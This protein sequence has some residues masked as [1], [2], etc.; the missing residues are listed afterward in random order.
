VSHL[1]EADYNSNSL[2]TPITHQSALGTD[3]KECE[4]NIPIA[5]VKVSKCK[6]TSKCEIPTINVCKDNISGTSIC[7]RQDVN[8]NKSEKCLPEANVSKCKENISFLSLNVCGL[9]SKLKM[10]DFE[11]YIAAVDVIALGESNICA[12]DN[13]N[14]KGFKIIETLCNRKGIGRISLLVRN[15]LVPHVSIINKSK[16]VVI[17]FKL[18]SLFDNIIFGAMYIPPQNSPHSNICMFDSIE[19]DVIELR[20]EFDCKLCIFGDTNART[21]EMDDYVLIENYKVNEANLEYEDIVNDYSLTELDLQRLNI[22]LQRKSNDKKT[23]KYGKRLIDLCK[24]LNLL[25]LNG[26]A[27]IDKGVGQ[28]TCKNASLVDYFICSPELFPLV[29]QFEVDTFDPTLS[30][31]HNPLILSLQSSLP[32]KCTL[33]GPYESEERWSKSNPKPR[34]NKDKETSFIQCINIQNIQKL[35]N[36][37]EDTSKASE[38][39]INNVVGGIENTLKTSA[40]ECGMIKKRN[41]HSK[42]PKKSVSKPWFNAD[43]QE[44]RKAFMKAKKAC[45]LINSPENIAN[46]KFCSSQYKKAT[47]QAYKEY[48]EALTL[49]L[50]SL[51]SSKPKEYWDILNDGR[52]GNKNEVYPPAEELFEHFRDMNESPNLEQVPHLEAEPL[53]P[54]SSD[55]KPPSNEPLNRPITSEEITKAVNKLKNNKSCGLDGIINEYLKTTAP[56][57]TPLFVKLFNRVLDTGIIPKSWALGKIIPIFKNKGDP[58]NPNSYRGITI[59]SC[60]GKLFTAI[61]NTRIEEYLNE[62]NLLG[63]EQ[64]GFRK[65]H[66]T[67]DHIFLLNSLID[68]YLQKRKRLY[69]AF[70]DYEKAF[71]KIDRTLLWTKLIDNGINGKVLSV[72]TNLYK[73][74]KSCIEKEGRTS[75]FFCC[76]VGVRQGENLSP[77]LF[78]LYL[79]DLTI[80]LSPALKGLQVTNDLL[81]RLGQTKDLDNLIKLFVL[82]YADDTT[83]LAD[84]PEALQ[85]GL[86][87]MS[88]YCTKWKIKINVEKT[89]IVVFSRGKIRKK[90]VFSYNDT[91]IEIVDDFVYLGTLINY[92]GKSNKTKKRTCDQASKAMFSIIGKAR[93]LNLPVEIQMHLF[94]SVVLPI[95]LYG[96]EVWGSQ[97]VRDI[98]RVH[99]KFCKMVLGLSQYTSSAMVYGETGRVPLIITIKTRIVAF[100]HKLLTTLSPK[101]SCSMY[102]LLFQVVN[103]GLGE[104]KWINFVQNILDECGLSYI[105]LNQATTT[106]DIN[107][108]WLKAKIKMSLTDQF[109]QQWHDMIN[110]NDNCETYRNFKSNITME[111]YLLCL[112]FKARNLISKFRCKNFKLPASPTIYYDPNVPNKICTLCNQYIGDEIHYLLYCTELQ[113][114]RHLLNIKHPNVIDKPELGLLIAQ[115]SE[116]TTSIVNFSKFLSKLSKLLR[117]VS[118]NK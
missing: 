43:C 89:K 20:S 88:E 25:I 33:N 116:N 63:L 92:N 49:K 9:K 39:V 37:L 82:L 79:N 90:P 84:S 81:N 77:I 6:K 101:L 80:F 8:I 27:G 29:Q 75:S 86:N 41:R 47:K 73:E 74:A 78:A 50:R 15:E 22:V 97:Q 26:R 34:W 16:D 96:C 71:D 4:S 28:L 67:I 59:L 111:K 108:D 31:A 13:I 58:A 72:I 3:L 36:E 68:L 106:K 107:T 46:V 10:P 83:I 21:G 14:V 76:D 117:V 42:N 70:I 44:K 1:A 5:N 11:N 110:T 55:C 109:T 56:I 12:H 87:V 30:D 61:L 64:A 98:E 65:N 45:K 100:W 7:D 17:W 24:G 103:N 32:E 48:H 52:K 118:H 60:L 53:N 99:L 51:K 113:N 91:P 93:K 85:N 18:N 114:D 95:L 57:L 40:S 105:W 38:L 102:H 19:Q 104:S 35:I 2:N 66:S 23:N 62:S 112:P 54:K 69:C 94:D 115:M